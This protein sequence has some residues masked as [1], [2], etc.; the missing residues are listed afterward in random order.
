MLCFSNKAR[1][2]GTDPVNKLSF[3]TLL[4]RILK[5]AQK[6]YSG[7]VWPALRFLKTEIIG[8]DQALALSSIIFCCS[9]IFILFSSPALWT[10]FKTRTV[11][12]WPNYHQYTLAI[13]GR[14]TVSSHSRT[15]HRKTGFIDTWFREL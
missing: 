5:S 14:T 7:I 15:R 13:N 11:A 9:Q 10:V 4:F 2:A 3:R 12:R 6:R 1:F 8:Q